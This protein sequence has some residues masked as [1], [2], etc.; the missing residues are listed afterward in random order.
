MGHGVTLGTTR[1]V[2]AK[3]MYRL[4]IDG[5]EGDIRPKTLGTNQITFKKI[6]TYESGRRTKADVTISGYEFDSIKI[7]RTLTDN[8]AFL[9]WVENQKAGKEDKRNGVLYWLDTEGNDLYSQRVK[10]LHIE[11]FMDL[12]GDASAMEDGMPEEISLGVLE[13]GKRESV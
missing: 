5:I 3:S 9:E 2:V 6:T 11:T 12:D 10:G 13:K 7:S 4:V 8:T 1:K